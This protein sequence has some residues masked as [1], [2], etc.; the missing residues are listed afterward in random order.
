MTGWSFDEATRQIE[1]ARAWLADRDDL[2]RAI[3]RAGLSSPDRLRDPYDSS[4]GGTDA[5]VELQAERA[6]VT[7]YQAVLDQAN[8]GRSFIERIGLLG[9][10]APD[11][12]LATAHGRFADGDLRGTADATSQARLR[13]DA[14]QTSG[15]LRLASAAVVVLVALALI[16]YLLRRR[17]T[18]ARN[19]D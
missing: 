5:Q 17:R 3:E 7:D 11:E 18:L 9:G 4:G 2:L 15:L 14:A 1:S 16:V 13:L 12:L 10:K 6:V 8:A 19:V